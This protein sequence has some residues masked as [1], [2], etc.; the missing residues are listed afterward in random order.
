MNSIRFLALAVFCLAF[1]TGNAFAHFGMLIPSQP[2]IME[3]KD[4]NIGISIRFWHPFENRGMPM[5]KPTALQVY[6]ADKAQNL[7][8]ALK[9]RT[10][11]G[12]PTWQAEYAI[13]RP[14]LYTF[15]M[16][17]K[18]YFEQ[19]EDCFITHIT[20]SYVSAFGGGEDWDKPLG[21]RAELVPLSD[22]SALYSGNLFQ[23][24][25]L[26]QGKAVP[27]AT[28]EIEWYPGEQQAGVAPYASMIT[29]T[30]KADDSGVF[31]FVAP[32]VGWWGFAALLQ[33]V[34][35]I[36]HKGSAK[37]VEL[38]AVAWVYFH[39]LLPAKER[40]SN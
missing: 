6:T 30:V 31:S 15:V 23:A 19:E 3:G 13:Q 21:L 20:K 2:T 36:Q 4:A 9:E 14:G 28:V 25:V 29:Q 10:E 39:P 5:E 12:V 26:H 7:L 24:K 34:Q 16:E 17:P 1:S 35:T 37:P 11:Q 40:K 38:G 18:P 22:P 27:G 33:D 32:R 8:P